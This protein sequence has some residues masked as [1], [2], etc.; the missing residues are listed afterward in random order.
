MS[1]AFRRTKKTEALATLAS[2]RRQIQ[3][4]YGFDP[5]DGEEI[6]SH[7]WTTAQLKT[8]IRLLRL[9]NSSEELEARRS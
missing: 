2:L 3:K 9:I 6:P 4:E 1:K 8:A 5:F 7:H